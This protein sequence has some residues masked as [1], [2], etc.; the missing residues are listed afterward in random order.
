MAPGCAEVIYE[1]FQK[2]KREPGYYD[3]I[4]TGDLGVYGIEIV[5]EYLLK[6]YKFKITNIKDSGTL[7]Y[8]CKEN[9]E[10]AG[11]SGPACLPLILFSNILKNKKYKKILIVGTGSLHSA[12]TSKLSLSIPSIAH[13]VSLEV[14]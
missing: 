11:G 3:V 13:A 12:I 8:N 10:F 14:L 7:L 1:H 2:T 9:D 5:K 6:K 4:L